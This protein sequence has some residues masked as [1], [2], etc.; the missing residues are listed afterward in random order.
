MD[1]TCL[2][3]ASKACTHSGDHLCR[4]LARAVRLLLCSYLRRYQR[5]SNSAFL[6]AS[7]GLA[8]QPR[9]DWIFR[10]IYES[11]PMDYKTF[12]EDG[13]KL[14]GTPGLMLL[15]Q[16]DGIGSWARLRSR[17]C[18]HRPRLAAARQ[19]RG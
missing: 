16:H 14:V 8:T 12:C 19:Q 9:P 3:S 7:D 13:P 10:S 15:Y 4:A 6:L 17:V 11:Q 2:I 1:A 18:F 5:L